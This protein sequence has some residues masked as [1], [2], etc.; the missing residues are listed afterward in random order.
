MWLCW[1]DIQKEVGA[2]NK[3]DG[4][5]IEVLNSIINLLFFLWI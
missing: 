1:Q 3:A 5:T 2:L 4:H